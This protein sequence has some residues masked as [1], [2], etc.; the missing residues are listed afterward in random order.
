MKSRVWDVSEK[1]WIPEDQFAITGSGQLLTFDK[2]SDEWAIETIESVIC[3][4]TGIVDLSG[5]ELFEG[6]VLRIDKLT[7]GSSAP[8]PDVLTV[9]YDHGV[10]ELYRGKQ[11]LF[12]LLLAYIQECVIIGNVHENPELLSGNV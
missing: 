9:V 4:G 2:Y 3:L 8:L 7:F 6:D 1:C 11:P 10:F 12:G 5:K